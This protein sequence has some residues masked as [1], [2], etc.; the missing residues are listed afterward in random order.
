MFRWNFKWTWM[1]VETKWD[2]ID[3]SFCPK[4]RRED[5]GH[6]R[7]TRAKKER[8]SRVV[9]QSETE[10]AASEVFDRW[11]TEHGLEN[12]LGD[13]FRNFGNG[14]SETSVKM[15]IRN[16]SCWRKRV[17]NHRRRSPCSSA[18]VPQSS[19]RRIKIVTIISPFRL[20][21]ADSTS[22]ATNSTPGALGLCGSLQW[23][24]PLVWPSPPLAGSL[25]V[26]FFILAL[27][28]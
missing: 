2:L 17:G 10:I 28:W 6:R 22:S 4:Q 23:R 16:S 18:S 12:Q 13:Q 27:L 7:Q 20:P 26:L 14:G 21:S 15:I 3:F 5:R 25:T 8:G 9:L 1:K 11:R 24:R 19:V